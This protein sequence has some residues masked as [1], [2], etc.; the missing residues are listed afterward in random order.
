MFD[1]GKK[2]HCMRPSA[3]LVYTGGERKKFGKATLFPFL[4]VETLL[5]SFFK[6]KVRCWDVFLGTWRGCG[7]SSSC[8]RLRSPRVSMGITC[9]IHTLDC[10]PRSNNAM[11]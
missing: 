6:N 2:G 5:F 4:L 7:G 10:S 8:W 11:P 3:S 1:E 9:S